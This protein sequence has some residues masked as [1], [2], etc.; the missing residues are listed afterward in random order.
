MVAAVAAIADARNH[1][2]ALAEWHSQDF[3][4]ALA[5][6]FNKLRKRLVFLRDQLQGRLHRFQRR[7]FVPDR[8][9]GRA[10]A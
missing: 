2:G 6:A 8:G 7:G 5:L 1:H 9:L 3:V 4:A 10:R